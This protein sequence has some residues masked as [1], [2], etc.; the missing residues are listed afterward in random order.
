[1]RV[2]KLRYC[3]SKIPFTISVVR[4]GVEPALI[5]YQEFPFH[6]EIVSVPVVASKFI[7]AFSDVK[8]TPVIVCADNIGNG[9]VE[10]RSMNKSKYVISLLFIRYIQL[11][12]YYI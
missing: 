6:F 5:L 10:Y 4:V 9:M 3:C 12:T 7:V 2:L 8:F 1:M 11:P